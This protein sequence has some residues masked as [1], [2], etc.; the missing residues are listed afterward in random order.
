MKFGGGDRG[1]V[2]R[3]GKTLVFPQKHKACRLSREG[4]RGL[5]CSPPNRNQPVVKRTVTSSAKREVAGSNPVRS[6]TLSRD[7]GP[8]AQRI[9]RENVRSRPFPG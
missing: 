1:R 5:A 8:V 9:E 6:T 4:L 2:L 3:Q 7:W